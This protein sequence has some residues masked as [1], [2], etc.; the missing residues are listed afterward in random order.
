VVRLGAGEWA[1]TVNAVC[2]GTGR[3]GTSSGCGVHVAPLGCVRSKISFSICFLYL[4]VL[5]LFITGSTSLFSVL[6]HMLQFSLY[7]VAAML[8]LWISLQDVCCTRLST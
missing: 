1:W 5:H 3:W 8:E 4:C 6:V 2:V 7:V